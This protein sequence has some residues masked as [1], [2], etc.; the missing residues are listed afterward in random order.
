[1]SN[2]KQ[3]KLGALMSYAAIL[4][5]IIAGLIYTPWMVR[6]IGKSDY[7]L[8]IL[9]ISFLTYFTMDFGLG[10]SIA[11]FMARYKAENKKDDIDN[12]LGIST[13][14]YLLIDGVI[15][16]ALVIIYF[17]I[18]NIFKELTPTEIEKF[19][20]V[21]II[22]GFFSLFSFP[23]TSL[24][25]ILIAFE[26]FFVLKL[27][28]LLKKAGTILFMVVAIFMGYKL[29]ALVAINAAVGL[30]IIGIKLV[31]LAKTTS[32]KVNLRFK[33]RE[34][35]KELF[36]FSAWITIIGIAQRLLLNI[37]PAILGIFSGTT[38]IAIFAIGTTLEGYTW[39]FANA[40]NGLFLP[41]VSQLNL[42]GE[43]KKEISD[44]MIKV[45]RIQLFITG[46]LIIGLVTMGK[47]FI[48]LWMGADFENSYY[49]A[50]LIIVT[51]IITLTQ[52]IGDTYI[53]VINK[54]K[55]QAYIL[56]GASLV[57][58]ILSAI[59]ASKYG[60]I[61]SA[62][63]IFVA[64]MFGKVIGMNWIYGKILKLD[65]LR[66]FRE[67]HLNMVIPF[68]I[69]ILS[70]FLIQKFIPVTTLIYFFSKVILLSIIYFLLMWFWGL[71]LY[72]KNLIRSVLTKIYPR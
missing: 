57:S 20:I 22:A 10:Q 52:Q 14:L 17:F 5:N 16:L 43:S 12:L 51:G 62:T 65:I 67:C 28:D 68:G 45:G 39:T 44:L 50:I 56:L 34:F 59:F 41:R 32:I 36:G 37:T 53:I 71:N 31:Y 49:V 21:Y 35:L 6:Q 18:E 70:G 25:G 27:C 19:K 60:A 38:Q 7:G 8:Y 66:F 54:L 11:R 42:K 1:M 4:F 63:A 24:N 33:S 30:I 13:R 15:L 23:F 40:L 55:F 48:T 2:S 61:G 47:E 64:L 9:V 3:I 46:L 69:T 26:R 29:F 72:E 58:I